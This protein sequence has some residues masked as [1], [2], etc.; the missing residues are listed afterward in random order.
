[1]AR[2]PLTF[3]QRDLIAAIKCIEATGNRVSR[4]EIGEGRVVVVVAKSGEDTSPP[5]NEWDQILESA[6]DV[7][8]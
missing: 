6:P 8:P 2:S 3:R 5:S 7:R 4:V 1:M